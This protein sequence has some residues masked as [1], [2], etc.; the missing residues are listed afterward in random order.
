[1]QM[2]RMPM[3]RLMIFFPGSKLV[4]HIRRGFTLIELLVVIAIIA[5]L[6][7][8]LLPAL[9]KAK[10]RAKEIACTSNN[11]QIALAFLMYGSDNHDFLPPLNSNSFAT[12]TPFWWWTYLTNYIQ[13]AQATGATNSNNNVWRCPEVMD[14]QILP[15]DTA[16]FNTAL[17]G[18]GPVEGSPTARQPD[19]YLNGILRF[20]IDATDNAPL[21]SLNLSGIH[22]PSQLWLVGDVGHPLVAPNI[23]ALPRGGYATDVST[24]VPDP[25]SGW[26][27]VAGYHQPAC[28]HNGNAVCCFCDGHVETLKW[29]SLRA[30]ANDIFGINSY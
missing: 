20:T 15:S 23:D 7:A 21:N 26:T 25:N 12:M 18:Y 8:M 14:A 6:A 11:R 9:A 28:R 24:K 4:S 19:A 27:A 29:A 1:M 10:A 30:D 2:E 22:R 13:S 17:L 5:I 16:Y 3:P